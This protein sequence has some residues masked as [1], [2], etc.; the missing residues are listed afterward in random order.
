MSW[1]L[2]KRRAHTSGMY[3]LVLPV[4]MVTTRTTERAE[5][6]T[7]PFTTIVTPTTERTPINQRTKYE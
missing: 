5:E 2:R 6:G 4:L 7:R 1:P 3:M